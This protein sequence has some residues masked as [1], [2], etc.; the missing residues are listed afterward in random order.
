[1]IG[2]CLNYHLFAYHYPIELREYSAKVEFVLA[3][4]SMYHVAGREQIFG[5]ASLCT[6]AVHTC[7]NTTPSPV[8]NVPKCD[9]QHI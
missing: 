6:L 7:I 4:E 9:S 3:T 1:M 2:I 8:S 5:Q